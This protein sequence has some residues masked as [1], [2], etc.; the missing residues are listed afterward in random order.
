MEDHFAAADAAVEWHM[1]QAPMDVTAFVLSCKRPTEQDRN[2]AADTIECAFCVGEREL[3]KAFFV[4]DDKEQK[5]RQSL[6]SKLPA[7]RAVN[8][9]RD[10]SGNVES[11]R[12][13][14]G[15]SSPSPTGEG[16]KATLANVLVKRVPVP[17]SAEEKNFYE[18]GRFHH[19][20]A[21]RMKK[22]IKN[23]HGV[24]VDFILKSEPTAED[25]DYQPWQAQ[26]NL[27]QE[28]VVDQFR[29][30]KTQQDASKRWTMYRPAT[31]GGGPQL[32]GTQRKMTTAGGI[33]A[34]A[35]SAPAATSSATQA[36]A[37]KLVAQARDVAL[38]FVAVGD[39]PA[40]QV[41]MLND[42]LLRAIQIGR[43]TSSNKSAE[44]L[45]KAIVPRS[46][47]GLKSAM[48][49]K[50]AED[51]KQ[52]FASMRGKFANILIDGGSFGN[53]G[54]QGF[55]KFQAVVASSVTDTSYLLLAMEHSQKDSTTASLCNIVKDTVE[56]LIE[57]GAIPLLLITDNASAMVGIP[58]ELRMSGYDM[59]YRF[60]CLSHLVS[61]MYGSI[62]NAKL[63]HF[64]FTM[65]H[66]EDD[67]D[68]DDGPLVEPSWTKQFR[69]VAH[70][71]RN[72]N[73]PNI[74][75]PVATRWLYQ[76]VMV[77]SVLRSLKDERHSG[78]VQ[79]VLANHPGVLSKMLFFDIATRP[80]LL[81][82]TIVQKSTTTLFGGLLMTAYLLASYETRRFRENDWSKTSQTRESL[83]EFSDA[84]RK[85]INARIGEHMRVAPMVVV[86]YMMNVAKESEFTADL[87]MHAAFN[88][89]A[90]QVRSVVYSPWARRIMAFNL[91]LRLAEVT[92]NMIATAWT[93][94]MQRS[95]TAVKSISV[96][97][98]AELADT[99]NCIGRLVHT[100]AR[101]GGCTESPCEGVFSITGQID[102][103]NMSEATLANR[104]FILANKRS[105]RARFEVDEEEATPADALCTNVPANI[106]EMDLSTHLV[107]LLRR[108]FDAEIA[109]QQL[110]QAKQKTIARV[111]S[112]AFCRKSQAQ[113][114]G[115]NRT[116]CKTQGCNNFFGKNCFIA[117]GG[118][119]ISYNELPAFTCSTCSN[120]PA[121]LLR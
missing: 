54:T 112:C 61:L 26:V 20:D 49:E 102:N 43:S 105:V 94:M 39:V 14:A 1:H 99:D 115:G 106:L 118:D 36:E 16:S 34:K 59:V 90:S 69:D 101:D 41:G 56:Q 4:G 30:R 65:D 21:S 40:A 110:A 100:I 83:D 107:A 91:R 119:T 93:G 15:T 12:T 70:E 46:E 76:S 37:D 53:G 79:L 113:C 22:H 104:A 45:A 71:L 9:V 85:S 63:K 25:A 97:D 27:F 72:S 11:P 77:D 111:G 31:N 64:S 103:L 55:R 81:Y 120:P 28:G 95:K 75:L 88:A 58:T 47:E 92:D 60:C 62:M 116:A 114:Q 33:V 109:V 42:L 68:D 52:N 38:T 73:V 89:V 24:D 121:V 78:T 13:S 29:H 2:A 8:E 87:N 35:D 117:S 96:D 3:R 51:T 84:A 19:F 17:M 23:N 67:D 6:V 98:F 48:S 82:S 10:A 74:L 108:V 57:N 86:G 5:K 18:H 66:E 7:P 80:L 32:F 50:V 44:Q